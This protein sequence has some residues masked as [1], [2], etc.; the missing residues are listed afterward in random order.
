MKNE[1]EKPKRKLPDALKAYCF[2]KG[3]KRGAR[4]TKPKPPTSQAAPP[5]PSP[6]PARVATA[7]PARSVGLL[8]WMGF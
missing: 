2:K 6:V 8:E 1:T 7:S 5:A 4:G 3:D